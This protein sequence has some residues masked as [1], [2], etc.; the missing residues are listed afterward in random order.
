VNPL[1]SDLGDIVSRFRHLLVPELNRGQ[2]VRI[3]RDRYLLPFIAFNKV[4][5]RP[6]RAG[7][8]TEHVES[9]LDGSK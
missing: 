8:L 4:Q 1:P 7:E 6:F 2:L 5:G 3:L 9:I